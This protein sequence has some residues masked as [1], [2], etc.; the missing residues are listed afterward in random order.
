MNDT[1][2]MFRATTPTE[3]RPVAMSLDDDG[4]ELTRWPTSPTG[5]LTAVRAERASAK[6]VNQSVGA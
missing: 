2:A 1:T 6:L 4:M 3:F 5:I